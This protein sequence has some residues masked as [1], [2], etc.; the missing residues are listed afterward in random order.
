MQVYEIFATD[1]TRDIPPVIYFHEQSP[2]K[3]Q[4]EVEEYIITGGY[5]SDDP[6]HSRINDGIH[7]QFVRL[8]GNLGKELKKSGGS[9]LPACWISG[10]FGSGKSSFAKLL[11]YA[12]DQRQLPNGKSLAQALLDR[13]D[14]PL[15]DEFRECWMSALGGLDSLAVVFDIGGA[16]RDDEHIHS[17]IK[18]KLQARL[19]YCESSSTVADLELKLEV[20]GHWDRF[21]ELA[22]E[23]LKRPWSEV[24]KE[25]L[26]ENHCSKVMH[27]LDPDLYEDPMAWLDIHTGSSKSRAASVEEVVADIQAMLKKRAPNKTLFVV[28]DEVSQYVH[29]DEQRMLKLQSFVEALGQR[30]KGKVWLMATGQQKLEEDLDGSNLSKLKDRFPP[31]LRVHLAPTNIRDVVHKRLLKKAPHK[32]QA[33]RALYQEHGASL[34][35]NGYACD[36]LTENDFLEVYPMLPGYVDLVMQITTNLR[37]RSTRMKGDDHAIR[38]LLQLLGEV[39]RQCKFGERPLGTL[40]TLDQIYDIQRSALDADVQ[41]TMARLQAHDELLNDELTMRVAKAVALLQ[42]L[43]LDG[44][45]T[46]AELVAQ[47]LYAR[48]GDPSPKEA[49][50]KA[51][52]K[53]DNLNLVSRSE[54]NGYRIQSSAEQEW[55]RERDSGNA[56]GQQVAELVKEKLKALVSNADRPKLKGRALPLVAL[57]SDSR[58]AREERLQNSSDSASLT[59]DFQYLTNKDARLEESWLKDSDNSPR[60]DR[61]VWV[62]GQTDSFESKA[63]D[64]I[65]SRDIVQRNVS[66]IASLT[67]ARKNALQHEQTR[68][69][70][71]DEQVGNVVAAMFLSGTVYFRA[72]KIDHRRFGTGFGSAL[73]GAAEEILPELFQHFVDLAITDKELEFLRQDSLA[74]ASAKF[75]GDGLGLLE[76]DSGK[77]VASCQGEVPTRIREYVE[78]EDGATGA[79]LISRFGGPPWG[80]AGDLVRACVLGLLRGGHCRIHPAKGDKISSYKDPGVIDL[81]SKDREFKQAEI[82]PAGEAAIKSSDRVKIRKFFEECTQKEFENENEALADAAFTHLHRFGKELIELRERIQKLQLP[83]KLPKALDE[84]EGTLSKCLQSR[85]IEATVV[86]VKKHLDG[87]RDGI[88]QLG[89][90]RGDLTEEA[91]AQVKRAH[92]FRTFELAQLNELELSPEHQQWSERLEQQLSSDRPWDGVS[93]CKPILEKIEASYREKRVALLEKQEQLI[94]KI[95]E[96]LKLREGFSQLGPDAA[97]NVLRLVRDQRLVTTPE[98]VSPS[99]IVLRDSVP[100]RLKDGAEAAHQRLEELLSEKTGLQVVPVRLGL[101]NRELAS[102]ADVE[103]LLDE[104]RERLM[105]QLQG[106][107]RI[108]LL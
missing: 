91:I 14:S 12:L 60:R 103:S 99:L 108:R 4:S 18:R 29:Q 71:L 61:L 68:R 77:M 55:A 42:Q 30:L 78:S 35:L 64:L 63:K 105:A 22:Q 85:Q 72:R 62:C 57:Y 47:C 1:V 25:K 86:A 32:E 16:A 79:A 106:N 19:G 48:V 98:A 54:K 67:E 75:M 28:V 38:G 73:K 70:Q 27:R 33:L 50:V 3:L 6:R 90:Y 51:L 7:E 89:Q 36:K 34:R 93:A 58:G 83:V 26:V 101:Q 97:D 56:S 80:Y 52:E 66:R 2:E 69:D 9:D 88:Q 100:K 94:E 59:I 39:F 102:A 81:F 43:Q 10:F 104:L 76:I 40:V 49:V 65:R 74:G 23:V 46:T 45:A 53:L 87:L 15:Q 5:R 21:L 82:V 20:D 31:R 24:L 107:S 8:V 92:R 84:L 17:A 44:L 41:N 11:G 13:D 37:A 96:S 95:I